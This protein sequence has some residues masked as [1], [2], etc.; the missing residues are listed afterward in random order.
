MLAM[1]RIAPPQPA[2][3]LM[4]IPKLRFRRCAHRIAARYSLGVRAS[5]LATPSLLLPRPALLTNARC[6]L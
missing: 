4:S 2:Q 6:A 3:V 5:A 1:M